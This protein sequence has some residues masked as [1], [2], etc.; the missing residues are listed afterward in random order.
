MAESP[1][2]KHIPL[3]RRQREDAISDGPTLMKN[4]RIDKEAVK[5]QTL[6]RIMQASAAMRLAVIENHPKEH[7]E[8]ILCEGCH[9][10]AQRAEGPSSSLVGECRFCS[11]RNLCVECWSTCKQCG[12][13]VCPLCSVKDYS[14]R[15]TV[16]VCLDCKR[17]TTKWS[18]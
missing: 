10:R 11:R 13:E 3:K 14:S 16:S 6:K 5:Q 9:K 7:V 18:R 12:M 15:D 2:T 17:H 1:G 8:L 4:V